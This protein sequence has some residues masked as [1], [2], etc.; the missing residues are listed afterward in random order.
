MIFNFPKNPEKSYYLHVTDEETEAA[1]L[2]VSVDPKVS[3][4]NSL[5]AHITISLVIY[6]LYKT[7][8]M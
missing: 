7:C 4:L 6:R 8:C 2:E 1:A 5:L 3:S